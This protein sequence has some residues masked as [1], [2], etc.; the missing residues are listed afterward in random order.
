MPF[1]KQSV[2]LGVDDFKIW[3]LTADTSSSLTYSATGYD[4]PGIQ[5]ISLSPNF[6]EKGLKG[7]EQIMDYYIKLDLIHWEFR[8]AKINLDVLKILEGGDYQSSGTTPNQIYTYT[9]LGSNTPKYFKMEGQIKY[10]AG[11]I[12][13]FHFRLLKCKA[14]S[15]QIEHSTQDYAIVSASGIA[16]PTI[17]NNKIKELLINETASAIP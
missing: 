2:L 1:S 15:V 4:V 17:N 6:T 13:D 3:E 5:K 9:L 10:S 7:D 11:E 12:G 8:S 14:N 16:I